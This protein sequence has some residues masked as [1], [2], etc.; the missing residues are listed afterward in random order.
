MWA[1]P[2]NVVI[3]A[4]ISMIAQSS[5]CYAYILVGC[6]TDWPVVVMVVVVV[7]QNKGQM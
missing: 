3:P 6:Q 1:P 5:S 7:K 2:V 4:M